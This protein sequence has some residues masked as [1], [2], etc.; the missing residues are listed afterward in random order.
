MSNKFEQGLERYFSQPQLQKIRSVKIGIAGAGGLGSNCA[1]FLVRS[2]FCHFVI[3]DMD[4]VDA[5]NL[6][7]QNYFLDQVDHHK[8]DALAENLQRINPAVEVSVRN[9]RLG[10][11]NFDPVFEDCTILVEAFDKPDIKADF[12]E[13]FA[14]KGKFLVMA[15][16]LAG[17][18]TGNRIVTRQ[19]RPD[20]YV[21]GDESNG[22]DTAPPLAPAVTIAAAKEADVVLGYVLGGVSHE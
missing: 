19:V 13:H 9:C 3:V 18:G 1:M 6:N 15:S 2:G 11:E 7:R 21:V 12:A 4:T 22:I 5:S 10:K 17:F 16:G 14:G 8:V 20:F